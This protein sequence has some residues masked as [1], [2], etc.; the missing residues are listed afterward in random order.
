M[1]PVV[2]VIDV[3]AYHL[4]GLVEGLELVAPDAALL[5]V[6]ALSVQGRTETSGSPQAR[7][8]PHAYM[9]RACSELRAQFICEGCGIVRR[10]AGKTT[11]LKCQHT[12]RF[13][14]GGT[15]RQGGDRATVACACTTYRDDAALGRARRLGL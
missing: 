12:P 6:D 10:H 8:A 11:A 13:E 7:A 1:G 14:R 3:G 4:P 2:V 5:E 9:P 15:L